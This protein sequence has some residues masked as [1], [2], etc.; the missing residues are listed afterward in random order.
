MLAM[1]PDRESCAKDA[2]VFRSAEMKIPPPIF[3]MFPSKL[4]PVIANPFS[5]RYTPPVHHNEMPY[6]R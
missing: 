5:A 6:C 4:V 1:L 2:P 3:A